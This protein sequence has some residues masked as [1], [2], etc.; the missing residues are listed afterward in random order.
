ME[1]VIESII[2]ILNIITLMALDIHA[3]SINILVFILISAV[4]VFIEEIVIFIL[5]R[6]NIIDKNCSIMD[7]IRI[8]FYEL[9][10]F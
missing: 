7:N 4:T 6:I 9:L 1:L 5:D 3:D 2:F 8:F 10:L